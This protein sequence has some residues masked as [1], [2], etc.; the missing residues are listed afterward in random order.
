M[1]PL[2]F[3]FH[4]CDNVRI[5]RKA[6]IFLSM[7]TVLQAQPPKTKTAPITDTLHGVAITD[8]YRWLEDQNSPETRAW[9]DSQMAYTQAALA[10]VPEREKIRRRLGELMKIDAMAAP[11]V[12]NGR[13][14]I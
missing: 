3:P 12:R 10:K 5:M 9:I 4:G 14:F 7:L 6:G 11:S 8:P 2:A 1:P 13:Y